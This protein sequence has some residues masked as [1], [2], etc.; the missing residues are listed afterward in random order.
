MESTAEGIFIIDAQKPDFPVIYANQS[1]Q[2]MTGYGRGDIL[3]RSYF[4]LY[5]PG[6]DPRVIEREAREQLRYAKPG[7]VVLVLPEER[8]RPENGVAR[9][10][11]KP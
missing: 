11:E 1:F 9:N 8:Q 5:G 4:L 6:A 3:G 7:E 2:K 10:N